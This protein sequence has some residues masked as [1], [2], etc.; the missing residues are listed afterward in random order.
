MTNGLHDVVAADT[1]LS[2][3][4]PERARLW[5]RGRQRRGAAPTRAAGVR[6]AAPFASLAS[7]PSS[8]RT[9]GIGRR[10]MGMSN[11]AHV[12]A[13]EAAKAA[14]AQQTAWGGNPQSVAQAAVAAYLAAMRG[15]GW[16]LVPIEPTEDMV[17]A[18]YLTGS[19][20]R[21]ELKSHWRAM[22]NRA[23]NPEI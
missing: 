17:S 10:E 22:L 23:P 1:V 5:L 18:V 13:V 2:H 8:F 16:R 15:A 19:P 4:D 9:A 14:V 3:S 21:P 12:A 11:S 6:F 20:L 7:V